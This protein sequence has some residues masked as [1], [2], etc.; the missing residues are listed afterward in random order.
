VATQSR[1]PDELAILASDSGGASMKATS[2]DPRFLDGRLLDLDRGLVSRRIFADEQ[3]HEREMERIF[4]HC[5]LFLGH[6]SML[7]R[8]GDFISNYM[9]EDPVIVWR[10]P[11]GR[12]HAFL[13]NCSHRGNKLCLYDRGRTV[14]FSCSYH[15]WTFNSEGRLVGVP[16]LEDAYYGKLDVDCLGLVEVPRIATHGGMIFGCWDPAAL[17][18][19]EYLG[20][21]L[22]YFDTLFGDETGGLE[23]LPGC[24]RYAIAGNWKLFC[25]NFAG[26]G[27][28]VPTSH[29]SA[30]QSDPAR[31][32]YDRRRGE[33]FMV[34]LTP[35]HGFGGVNVGE[36]SYTAD[37]ARAEEL[38]PEA[39]EYVRDR[40][41]RLM[42]RQKDRP[43]R[44][45]GWTW[46]QWFPTLNLQ[47]FDTALRGRLFILCHPKGPHASDIW[48]WCFV[49]RSAPKVVRELI[50]KTATR[51]QSG[52]GIIGIDDGENFDRITENTRTVTSRRLASNYAMSLNVESSWPGQDDWPIE[53]LPGFFGPHIWESS[54]RRFYRYWGQLMG[55]EP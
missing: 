48:E 20:D 35:A 45:S 24:Q 11:S 49:E 8:P 23:A 46:G 18:L 22:W 32:G 16:F 40:F 12:V 42:D 15:G 14:S 4:H 34:H 30:F 47:A 31:T 25:D 13:N 7:P 9:G 55:I 26:D 28:H 17:S 1:A 51:G 3:L 53:E 33:T 36:G 44:V 2:A 37:L 50:A 38:G 27:Y 5:W 29:A 19:E 6:E 21:A 41:E 43:A 10:D 39:V 54:Q 52:S